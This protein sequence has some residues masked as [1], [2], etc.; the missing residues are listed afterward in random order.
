M[1]P[2]PASA[3]S[4]PPAAARYGW[5]RAVP[6]TGRVRLLGID[7]ATGRVAVRVAVPGSCG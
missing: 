6:R 2:G 5:T 1:S 3:G 4:W 7:P